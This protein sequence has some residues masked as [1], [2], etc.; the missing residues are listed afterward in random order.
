MVDSKTNTNPVNEPH[1]QWR[2]EKTPF[3]FAQLEHIDR[4]DAQIVLVCQ[5][6]ERWPRN[7]SSV[8]Q[9]LWQP[10]LSQ[11]AQ[12]LGSIENGPYWFY[13]PLDPCSS[14]PL[15]WIFRPGPKSVQ[16]NQIKSFQKILNGKYEG[17]L[18]YE[19]R[20][21]WCWVPTNTTVCDPVITMYLRMLISAE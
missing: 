21:T 6:N 4:R 20:S 9:Y 8:C 11:S 5:E 3:H 15:C 10:H 1:L 7:L 19:T 12:T 14:R 13:V 2:Q 16:R 18:T 17:S